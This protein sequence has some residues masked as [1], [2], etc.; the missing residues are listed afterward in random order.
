VNVSLAALRIL[1][2]VATAL[3]QVSSSGISGGGGGPLGG[4][5]GPAG[6]LL[7]SARMKQGVPR[8][9]LSLAV[10]R[11]AASMVLHNSL[12]YKQCCCT[13]VL[14]LSV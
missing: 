13:L 4:G 5:G 14:A 9:E 6:G 10:A 7:L 2:S 8:P 1:R 12:T 11:A 3:S